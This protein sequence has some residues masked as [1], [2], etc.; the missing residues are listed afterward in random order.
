MVG[1]VPGL[2]RVSGYPCPI[3]WEHV[4]LRLVWGMLG[5]CSREMTRGLEMRVLEGANT[6]S[7]IRPG[8]ES[9]VRSAQLIH[10]WGMLRES[11]P[12]SS[13]WWW[14]SLDEETFWVGCGFFSWGV[15]GG[16]AETADLSSTPESFSE[17]DMSFRT[18]WPFL[19]Y[20]LY[21]EQW[22]FLFNIFRPSRRCPRSAISS[23]CYTPKMSLPLSL[24]EEEIAWGE[25]IDRDT[26]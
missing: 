16:E 22:R 1:L 9:S 15:G 26:R 11:V 20:I 19:C 18:L 24:R 12:G 13:Y 10:R 3:V 23:S 6:W 5:R 2:G 8:H 25:T 14:G 17:D 7:L 4:G 21:M